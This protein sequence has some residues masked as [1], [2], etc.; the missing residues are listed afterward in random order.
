[1]STLFANNYITERDYYYTEDFAKKNK[2][3]KKVD[4]YVYDAAGKEKVAE[5]ILYDSEGKEVNR[6]KGG[7]TAK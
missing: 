5:S 6:I 2:Y 7:E 3:S 1:M 4:S